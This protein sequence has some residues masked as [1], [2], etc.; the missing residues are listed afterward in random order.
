MLVNRREIQQMIRLARH[1]VDPV[2]VDRPQWMTFIDREIFGPAVDLPRSGMHDRD[3]GIDR[4]ARFQKL[5]LR[6]AVDRQVVFGGGHRIEVAGLRRQ[7]ERK[8]LAGEQMRQG[9]PAANVGNVDRHPIA[10]IGDI[11]EVAAIFGNHAVDEQ[12]LGA[13]RD[14]TP[15][16]RR[17][18][19]T[20]TAGNHRPGAGIG[21]KAGIGVPRFPLGHK[22]VPRLRR[23]LARPVIRRA[24]LDGRQRDRTAG[25]SEAQVRRG[26]PVFVGDLQA[27][28]FPSDKPSTFALPRQVNLNKRTPPRE[29]NSLG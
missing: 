25:Y 2:H 7:V 22:Y 13:E 18:D 9:I 19:Q 8:I 10:Y 20:Q 23:R 15:R 4:P 14:Q 28:P 6:R 5:Q 29:P 3:P 26:R 21:G 24:A 27:R 1:L 17:A 12:D 16:D 11:G